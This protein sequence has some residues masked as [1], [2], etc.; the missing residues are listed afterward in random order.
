MN[1]D[2]L[3]DGESPV[4]PVKKIRRNVC[5]NKP[6]YREIISGSFP[7]PR[8]KRQRLSFWPTRAIFVLT[9]WRGLLRYRDSRWREAVHDCMGYF[10]EKFHSPS[11]GNA[12][13]REVSAARL[14]NFA[15]Q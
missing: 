1:A 10:L 9:G 7:L 3:R 6:L 13:C 8:Q 4:P 12:L 15:V 14:Q 5:S 2:R 11:H